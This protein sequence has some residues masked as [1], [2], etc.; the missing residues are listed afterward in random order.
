MQGVYLKTPLHYYL[1]E[2]LELAVGPS[3]ICVIYEMFHR[4]VTHKKT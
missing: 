4:S 1:F 2:G 3:L